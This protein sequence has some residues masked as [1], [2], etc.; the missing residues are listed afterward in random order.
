MRNLANFATTAVLDHNSCFSI[1]N[2]N[3]VAQQAM[4]NQVVAQNNYGTE[5]PTTKTIIFAGENIFK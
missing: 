4:S 1:N 5:R 3:N 2:S